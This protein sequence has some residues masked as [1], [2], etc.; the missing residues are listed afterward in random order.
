MIRVICPICGG[1]GEL[2]S[3]FQLY[4]G[5]IDDDIRLCDVCRGK[6][7]IYKR[8]RKA[9]RKGICSTALT[10]GTGCVPPGGENGEAKC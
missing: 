3:Q 6:G 7:Y 9:G 4:D 8:E 10:P 2:G 1:I 5:S